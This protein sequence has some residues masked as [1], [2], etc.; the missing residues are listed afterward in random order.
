M[1]ML[2]IFVSSTLSSQER[3]SYSRGRQNVFWKK[4]EQSVQTAD[5]QVARAADT[6]RIRIETHYA[7]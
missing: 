7:N 5:H 6:T 1:V 2:G 3:V 4:T